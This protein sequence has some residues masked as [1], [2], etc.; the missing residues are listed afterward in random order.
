M[1]QLATQT[2]GG[3]ATND[4]LPEYYKDLVSGKEW[5]GRIQQN[6]SNNPDVMQGKK[7]GGAF[8]HITSKE[9]ELDLGD[10]FDCMIVGERAHALSWA[11]EP[12][13]SYY[14]PK[15]PEFL[16]LKRKADIS[17]NENKC[18]YGPS[19]L[20]WIPKI[21]KFSTILLGSFTA[22]KQARTMYGFLN[23]KQPVTFKKAFNKNDKGAWWSFTVVSC[24]LDLPQPKE[25]D[26]KRWYDDFKNPK[27][28]PEK[29]TTATKD[30]R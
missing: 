9:E 15:S 8:N 6:A 10:E 30:D 28:G 23:A 13:V 25:E 5:L 21:Q 4:Q 26:F 7:V 20:L 2:S 3:I 29:D 17:S 11:S 27:A 12:P 14:D 19:F 24:S 16:E 1:S 18:V 22:K